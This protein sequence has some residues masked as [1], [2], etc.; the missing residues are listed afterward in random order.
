MAL[1]RAPPSPPSLSLP[2]DFLWQSAG[3]G[4]RMGGRGTPLRYIRAECTVLLVS[5][6]VGKGRHGICPVLDYEFA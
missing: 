1:Q 3:D 2:P 6:E 4:K 5:Q